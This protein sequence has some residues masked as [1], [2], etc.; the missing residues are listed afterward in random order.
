MKALLRTSLLACWLAAGPLTLAASGADQIPW[1]TDFRTACGLAAEQQ[2]LVLLHFT[3]DNCPPCR[4]VEAEVFSQ[5]KVA[6]AV[7][8]NYH[9]VLV[10]KEK[11]PQLVARYQVKL[12]PTDVFVTSSGLEVYRAISPQQ[13]A[14]FIGLLNQV[15]KQTGTSASRQ[16]SS[17]MGQLAQQAADQSAAL[18][19]QFQQRNQ[20]VVGAAEELQQQSAIVANSAEQKVASTAEQFQQQ[21]GA[22]NQQAQNTRDH[23]HQTGQQSLAAARTAGQQAADAARGAAQPWQQALAG[24]QSDMRSAFNPGGVSAAPPA[25]AVPPVAGPFANPTVTRAPNSPPP[26]AENPPPA[27]A[28]QPLLP[29]ANPWFTPEGRAVLAQQTPKAPTAPALQSTAPPLEAAPPSAVAS[30]PAT[31]ERSPLDAG[32]SAPP[33]APPTAPPLAAVAQSQPSTTTPATR[34]LENRQMV[35]ASQA[36]P[37]A[38]DGFCVVTLIET[39]AWKKADAKFGAIHRGRTYLFTSEAAQKKFLGNPDGFA[40]VLSGCDPVRFA[41]TGELVDGKRAYGL[42]TPDNRIFLFADEAALQTFEKSPG[43]FAA[44][45]QQAMLRGMTG[46]LYR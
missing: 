46:N 37:I 26:A 16:W 11:N 43:E 19:Q 38:L 39:K 13:P 8:T 40:P 30:R 7:A 14:D 20:Q 21:A 1:A 34:P 4:K 3:Q 36:P 18:G 29:T 44:A 41:K 10:Q 2:R 5:A 17:Q 32:P 31:P 28:Q 42:I 45:A 12:F 15:A 27:I 24:M 23:L 22:F 6:E 9:A 33:T 35:A 25:A